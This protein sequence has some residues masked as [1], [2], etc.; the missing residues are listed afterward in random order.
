[1]T[2]TTTKVYQQIASLIQ[3][4]QNCQQTG[5]TDWES[6]HEDRIYSL[7]NEYMPS[8]S[9]IDNGTS[10]D[11][12]AST[13]EKLVFSF[14]Y[15]HMNES[16]YYVGWSEHRLIVTPSLASGFDLRITGRDRDQIKE[17]L[18]DVYSAALSSIVDEV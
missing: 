8:G 12:D 7:V 3:A 18:A 13:P 11:L 6:R 17:Y 5:N 4:R 16:G 14:G 1:M 9:G 2:T 10:I 15:H